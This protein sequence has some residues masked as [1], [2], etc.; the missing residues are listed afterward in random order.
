MIFLK[1]LPLHSKNTTRYKIKEFID[2]STEKKTMQIKLLI[3]HINNSK[4]NNLIISL[5]IYVREET[6][7]IFLR[8]LSESLDAVANED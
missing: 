3:Q 8:E 2:F 1:L 7:E 6:E 5:E 4:G